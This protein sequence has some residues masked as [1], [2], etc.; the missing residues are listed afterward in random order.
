MQY[1]WR[2]LLSGLLPLACSARF[3]IKPRTTGLTTHNCLGPPIPITI[4]KMPCLLHDRVDAFFSFEALSSQK[5]FVSGW[6]RTI[7]PSRP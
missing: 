5:T 3:L 2:L 7:Q 1:P 6:R 4:K